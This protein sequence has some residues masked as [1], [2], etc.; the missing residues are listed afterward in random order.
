[1]RAGGHRSLPQGTAGLQNAGKLAEPLV[2]RRS[3]L[4]LR[5]RTEQ[6]TEV[7]RWHGDLGARAGAAGL[8]CP[9]LMTQR[10]NRCGPGQAS[11]GCP[12]CRELLPSQPGPVRPL[13]LGPGM[14][15]AHSLKLPLPAR[16]T[17]EWPQPL[18]APKPRRL[19]PRPQP[20]PSQQREAEPWN[21]KDFCSATTTREPLPQFP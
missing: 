14:L 5:K 7:R 1:M 19:G 2:R 15:N 17:G 4:S 13:P 9:G 3:C 11:L 6:Q 21:A 10:R 16:N 20:S 12:S 18:L 8:S